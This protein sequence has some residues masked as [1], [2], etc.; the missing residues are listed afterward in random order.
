MK[1]IFIKFNGLFTN[2]PYIDTSHSRRQQVIFIFKQVHVIYI[3]S[4]HLL[5]QL[6]ITINNQKQHY[7]I[8]MVFTAWFI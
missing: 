5:A 3:H 7:G 1:F 8:F 2:I 4:I 6:V